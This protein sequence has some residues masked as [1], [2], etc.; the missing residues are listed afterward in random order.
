MS[1]PVAEI[2]FEDGGGNE[3]ILQ[4][5]LEMLVKGLVLKAQNE[6]SMYNPLLIGSAMSTR[7]SC[8]AFGDYGMEDLRTRRR[9]FK[10]C[11]T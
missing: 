4:R 3:N 5:P 9:G 6:C 7:Y 2:I 11:L 8:C 10:T 1:V